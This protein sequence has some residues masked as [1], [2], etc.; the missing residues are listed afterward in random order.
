MLFGGI[1][2]LLRGSR[3][4]VAVLSGRETAAELSGLEE[5]IF[6][7]SGL[8]CRNVSLLFLPRGYLPG[9]ALHGAQ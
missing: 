3:Q 4:S 7:Y 2:S 8:G 1:P 5:D 6:S 9:V